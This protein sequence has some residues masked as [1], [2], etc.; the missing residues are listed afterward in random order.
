MLAVGSALDDDKD[1]KSGSVYLF[2]ST[3]GASSHPLFLV[4]FDY[5]TVS[6]PCGRCQRGCDSDAQCQGHL[7]CHHCDNFDDHA[8]PG[9]DGTPFGDAGYCV[10]PFYLFPGGWDYCT[11]SNP[12]RRCQGDC[13]SDAE[14][15]GDLVCHYHDNF[16]DPTPPGCGGT[17]LNNGDYHSDP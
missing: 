2:R 17:P 10:D 13:A 7:V 9:C 1:T 5:C 8:P 12:C 6:N 14:C 11:V 15:E 3:F 16:D 4:G